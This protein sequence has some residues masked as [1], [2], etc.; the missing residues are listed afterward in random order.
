MTTIHIYLNFNDKT[1]KAFKFYKSVFGGDFF[2]LQRYKDIPGDAKLSPADGEK[3]LHI[4]LPIAEHTQLHGS[5]IVP[6][7]SMG[8]P[9]KIG[10][11]IAIMI[12]PGSRQEADRFFTEL[13]EGGKNIMP[14]KD[15][16]WGD[17]FGSFTDQFGVEWMI[18]FE[19]TS[20]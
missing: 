7:M 18:N 4:G 5:D 2:M 3:I 11:N 9:L 15:E 6:G 17:Y 20:S 13:S 10:N 1:E 14:M 12:S 19:Q 16:F 8:E